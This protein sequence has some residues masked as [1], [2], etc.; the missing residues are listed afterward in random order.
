M[1][2][3]LLVFVHKIKDGG[4]R[5]FEL[6]FC[7]AGSPTKP[8]CGPKLAFQILHWSSLYFS[9]YRDL[10]ISQ[11]WLKMPIQAPKDHVLESFDPYTS[12]YYRDPQKALSCAETHVLSPN[13]SWSVLRC[14][15]DATRRVGKR[16]TKSKPKFAIFED[17]LPSFHINQ[18][19]HAGSYP[20]YCFWFWVSKR[21][22]EKCGSSEGRIFGYPIDLA[23][24]LY[25][26]LLLS[27]KPWLIDWLSI[28]AEFNDL[29]WP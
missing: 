28:G 7:N 1:A 18:I 6:L 16:K 11:I 8:V 27:H 13:W 26:S 21:S 29:K 3:E 12:F 4:R 5:H 22:V 23:H 10:K 2:A 14:D 15:L 19:L 24:G 9:R 17:P 25:I 20:G